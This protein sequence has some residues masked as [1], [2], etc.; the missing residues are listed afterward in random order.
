[1]R[2]L[3]GSP[4]TLEAA[5]SALEARADLAN[6]THARL[7]AVLRLL[8]L[9]RLDAAASALGG[10]D[11]RNVTWPSLKAV[12]ELVAAEIALRT[13]RTAS[14]CEAL[15]RAQAAAARASVPALVAE[16]AEAQAAIDRPAARRVQAG[17]EALLR[18]PDVEALLASDAL[19]VDGCRRCLRSRAVSNLNRN[20]RPG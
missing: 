13:L 12:A 20:T 18:L 5:A 10:L 11:M 6:A 16:V 3:G 2:D 9:G 15:T 4:R 14:A 1:M 17:G 19:V 7:I 8:L